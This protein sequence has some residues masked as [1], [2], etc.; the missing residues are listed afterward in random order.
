MKFIIKLIIA[1]SIIVSLSA[2]QKMGSAEYGVRF[3][4][5]PPFLG[6][7]VASDVVSPGSRTVVMPWESIYTIDTRLE[8]ISWGEQTHDRNDDLHQGYVYTRA[9]D[10]NELALAFTIQFRVYP[11]PEK[12]RNLVQNVALNNRDVADIVIAVGRSDIRR[13]MNEL[14]TSDFLDASKVNAAV[15]KVRNLMAATLDPYG[16]DIVKMI[17][18]N[19]RFERKLADGST[20]SSYQER[21]AEIQRLTEDTVRAELSVQ[22][23]QA[24]MD[25]EVVGMQVLRQQLEAEALGYKNQAKVRSD[26]YFEARSNEAKAILAQGEAQVKGMIEQINALAG[27]GGNAILKL[28]LAKQLKASDPKFI[29]LGDDKGAG[30]ELRKLDTNQLL[31]QVG[32]VEGLKSSKKTKREAEDSDE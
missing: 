7:G 12:I 4:K 22:A 30:L 29:L 6:G 25:Q 23:I 17:L 14:N 19:Y 13:V 18:L 32:L 15:D 27:P 11:D 20:D 1:L 26:A 31:G 21:L 8:Q 9:H 3:R 28:E 2:C 16:I 5:L 24:K 10:G